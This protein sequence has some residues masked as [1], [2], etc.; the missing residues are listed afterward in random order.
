MPPRSKIDKLPEKVRD[1]LDR[2][3]IRNGFGDHAQLSKWL[4][5]K[6]FKICPASVG[7][8]SQRL[9]RQVERLRIARTHAKAIQ[10]ES[11]DEAGDLNDAIISMIQAQV[12]DKITGIDLDE[13]NPED[14]KTLKQMGHMVADLARAATS[15]KRFAQQYRTEIRKEALRDAAAAVRASG[16]KAGISAKTL[17]EIEQKLLGL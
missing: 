6:G 11:G 5:S 7:T 3:L 12:F 16:K 4:A 10:A 17:R 13:L 15:Q 1:E 9:R 8:H 14:I 2:K